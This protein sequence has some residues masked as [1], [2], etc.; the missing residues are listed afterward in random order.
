MVGL[1]APPPPPLPSGMLKG[2]YAETATPA[3]RFASL[4]YY[5]PPPYLLLMNPF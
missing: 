5:S 1:S 4:I 2:G 3:S